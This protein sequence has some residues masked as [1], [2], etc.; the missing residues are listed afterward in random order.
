MTDTPF[1]PRCPTCDQFIRPNSDSKF[2]PFCS[3]RCQ[4]IDLGRWL[5]EENAI[6]A[7]RSEEEEQPDTEQPARPKLPPGW[8]DA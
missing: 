1:L 2:M 7:D 6:A 8:H 4:L 5:S 3:E